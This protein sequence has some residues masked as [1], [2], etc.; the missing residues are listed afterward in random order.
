[1][2]S[3]HSTHKGKLLNGLAVFIVCLLAVLAASQFL[4]QNE[5]TGEFKLKNPFKK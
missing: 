1:M 5:V 2:V 4:K 3:T